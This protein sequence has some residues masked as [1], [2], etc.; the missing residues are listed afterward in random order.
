VIEYQ[1]DV[2][3]NE[4]YTTDVVVNV[5][6][7]DAVIETYEVTLEAA[8]DVVSQVP[9]TVS[10]PSTGTATATATRTKISD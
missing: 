1:R 3:G 8:T 4:T 10:T 7:V 5:P 6:A 2:G 9:V